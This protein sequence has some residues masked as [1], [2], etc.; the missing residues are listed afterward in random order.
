MQTERPTIGTGT[1]GIS[2]RQG[3]PVGEH[4]GG[5]R[6]SVPDTALHGHSGQGSYDLVTTETRRHRFTGT[7]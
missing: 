7:S 4:S 2:P 5:R 1:R 3:Y 6:Y